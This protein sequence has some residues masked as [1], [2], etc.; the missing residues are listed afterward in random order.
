MKQHRGFTFIELMIVVLVIGILTAVGAPAYF[1]IKDRAAM[2]KTKS[3]MHILQ[4]AAEQFA[5]RTNGIYPIELTTQVREIVVGQSMGSTTDSTR[6]ADMC[7]ATGADVSTSQHALLPG[8]GAFV[9]PYL[10][11]GHCLDW[12]SFVYGLP[13]PPCF[14]VIAPGCSGQ[15]TVLWAPCGSYNTY[16]GCTRYAIYG[17]GTRYVLLE[18]AIYSWR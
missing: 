14:T 13:C 10:A 12:M 3:N 16:E 7:P 1:S 5:T 11:T 6:I 17:I 8:G 4:M 18:S 9:N 2:V 15:G